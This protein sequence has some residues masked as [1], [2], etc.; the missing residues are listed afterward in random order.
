MRRGGRG[1]R[2]SNGAVGRGCPGGRKGGRGRKVCLDGVV[3]A[4]LAMPGARCD[5]ERQRWRGTVLPHVDRQLGCRCTGPRHLSLCLRRF[6][7]ELLRLSL[8]LSLPS[9]LQLLL[10]RPR[11]VG[12]L[13]SLALPRRAWAMVRAMMKARVYTMARARARANVSVRTK[14]R[15]MVPRGNQD[16]QRCQGEGVGGGGTETGGARPK[17]RRCEDGG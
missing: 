9:F 17:K 12:L 5:A 11:G 3:A 7:L 16:R 10:A 13:A 2:T 1:R 15:A 8:R 6:G 14:S 4:L